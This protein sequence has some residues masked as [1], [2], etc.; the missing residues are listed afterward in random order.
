MPR[1]TNMYRG[2][3][4]ECMCLWAGNYA[5]LAERKITDA[6]GKVKGRKDGKEGDVQVTLTVALCMFLY[7]SSVKHLD[8]GK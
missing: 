6:P 4:R 1:G 8:V 2:L 7:A 5:C 3:R